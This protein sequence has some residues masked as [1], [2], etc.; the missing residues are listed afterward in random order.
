MPE[1]RIYLVGPDDH[2]H[3]TGTVDCSS[4]DEAVTLALEHMEHFVAV[5]VWCGTRL[6]GRVG[7][8]DE[9]PA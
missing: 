5:E 6:I 2:F 8:N 1:Y 4:D 3:K 9:W 7:L